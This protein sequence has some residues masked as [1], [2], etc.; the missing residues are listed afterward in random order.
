[1]TPTHPSQSQSECAWEWTSRQQSAL[2]SHQPDSKSSRHHSQVHQHSPHVCVT[3]ASNDVDSLLPA[4]SVSQSR[5]WYQA[6]TYL[7]QYQDAVLDS[8]ATR[9]PLLHHLLLYR[10]HQADSTH[11]QALAAH[12]P[13]QTNNSPQHAQCASN[14]Q[15]VETPARRDQCV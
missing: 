2:G 7:C 10:G 12:I 15:D 14:A 11:A 5:P 8:R 9:T 6:T 4:P 13:H 3:T 1:M